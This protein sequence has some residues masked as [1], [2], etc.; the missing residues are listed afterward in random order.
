MMVVMSVQIRQ[1]GKIDVIFNKALSV[2]PET[3]LLYQ[4]GRPPRAR[5][6]SSMR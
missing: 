2:L 4:R 5:Y 3:E 1:D 6:C